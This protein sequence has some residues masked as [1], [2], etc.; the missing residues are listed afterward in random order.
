MYQ[1]NLKSKEMEEQSGMR[2]K[3]IEGEEGAHEILGRSVRKQVN[4]SEQEEHDVGIN[5]K[6][7]QGLKCWS[8]T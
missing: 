6:W 8:E 5:R 3:L 4:N 1:N 7:L 2:L